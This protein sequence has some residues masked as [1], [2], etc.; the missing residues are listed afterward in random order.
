MN[1]FGAICKWTLDMI[2][3]T[4]F[5]LYKRINIGTVLVVLATANM[6]FNYLVFE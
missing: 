2:Y 6:V 5:T 3:Y 1:D 4:V